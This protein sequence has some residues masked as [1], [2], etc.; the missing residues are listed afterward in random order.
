MRTMTLGDSTMQGAGCRLAEGTSGWDRRGA[1]F[2]VGGIS[3]S[4]ASS[5]VIRHF[6]LLLTF[7]IVF[8]CVLSV[9]A[10]DPGAAFD[11]ANR[12]YEQGKYSEAAAAYQKLVQAGQVSAALYFN[13][14]NACFKA[15]TLGRALAAYRQAEALAPRDP[16]LR[17]NIQFARDQAQGPT[18]ALSRWQKVLGRLSLNEWTILAAAAVWVAFL[19]LGAGQ[20]WPAIQ[21]PLRS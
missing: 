13:L 7:A 12:L 19:L 17:A 8:L 20:L 9:R 4:K 5:F 14:G 1:G 3:A 11:A 6:S 18:L 16:D 21:A 15:G 2:P 10:E